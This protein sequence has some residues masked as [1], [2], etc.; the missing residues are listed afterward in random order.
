MAESVERDFDVLSARLCEELGPQLSGPYALFGHSMGA[1]LAYGISG[2]LRESG[3]KLPTALMVSACAAPSQRMNERFPVEKDDS[4]LIADLRRHG[5]T[6]DELF[7]NP[8]LLRMTV[9]L[10]GADYRICKSFG[11]CHPPPLP[12]PIH[13][14]AGREDDI[15]EHRLL[16]WKHESMTG[17]TLDWFDGGHFFIQRDEASLLDAIAT[18]LKPEG[19]R[20]LNRRMLCA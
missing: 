9:E 17:I 19:A 14:F 20:P 4:S 1:L 3:G 12:V 8:E 15:D 13:V 6:P 2:K 16:A 7:S 10:L 11:H 5:G 18:H